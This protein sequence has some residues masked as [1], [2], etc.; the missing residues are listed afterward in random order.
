MTVA[1][2]NAISSRWLIKEAFFALL[3][4][5][6]FEKVSVHAIV[7]KAGISRSTFYLHFRDK[8][9]LLEQMT[10]EIVGELL[11]MYEGKLSGEDQRELIRAYEDKLPIPGTIAICEHFRTYECFYRN[12][13]QDSRFLIWL[14]EELRLRFLRIY[15]DEAQATFAAGGT[16][17]FYGRWLAEGM[18]GTSLENAR[19]LCSIAMF[20]L[21]DKELAV[22]FAAGKI[23][24]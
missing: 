14:S 1:E 4:L 19:K 10:E 12:R 17:G 13:F 23:S 3:A 22:T 5:H 11:A 18:P 24:V 16:M 20:S 15:R 9:D 21:H 6:P 7:R 2:R 8:F